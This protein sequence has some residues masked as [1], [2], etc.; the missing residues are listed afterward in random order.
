M[1]LFVLH[2]TVL[3]PDLDLSLGQRQRMGDLD[4]P[5]ARQIAL[6]VELLLQLEDLVARV[7]GALPFRLHARFALAA[8]CTE[9]KIWGRDCG[10]DD[11][12]MVG[13]LI[14]RC[15]SYSGHFL[16]HKHHSQA[17]SAALFCLLS[18]LFLDCLFKL[19]T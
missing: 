18:I 17:I 13:I 3:E 2:A 15:A 6:G 5:L 10:W 19:T 16:F 8:H 1:I 7:C 11:E 12:M 4:A 9:M 14:G